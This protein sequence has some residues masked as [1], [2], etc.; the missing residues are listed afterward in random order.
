[1]IEVKRILCPTDFSEF[2][3][4]AIE[5]A[6]PMARWFKSEISVIHVVPRVLM[7]PEYFPYMQEPVLPSPDV[8]RQAQEEL[9]RYAEKVRQ[10]GIET[11]V[12][13]EEGD[14]VERCISCHDPLADDGAVKKLKT[15]YHKNCKACH[16]TLAKEGISKDAPY[17]HCT[18]C[19]PK[20]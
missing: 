12:C 1:M 2:S 13:L 6:L 10:T 3:D 14:S 9:D 8:R 7:H 17:R 4:W 19:H 11:E 15:A 5:L 16:Q 20:K 18:D